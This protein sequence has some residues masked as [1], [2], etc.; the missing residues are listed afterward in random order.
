[1]NIETLNRAITEMENLC[2]QCEHE[3]LELIVIC[4]NAGIPVNIIEL[5]E[6]KNRHASCLNMLSNLRNM[7]K[8][9]N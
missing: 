4:S 8:Y 9:V 3:S 1:M 7:I 6:I 2:E 5:I